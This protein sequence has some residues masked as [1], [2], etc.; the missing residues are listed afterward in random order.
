V[1]RFLFALAA[2]VAASAAATAH[3]VYVVPAPDG[4]E[5]AVT[6]VFSDNLEADEKVDIAKVGGL[7]LTGRYATGMENEI[8]LKADKHALKGKMKGVLP[9]VAFGSVDYG[10]IAKGDAKPALLR[11]HPKAV[12]AGTDEQSATIGK[13]AIELVPVVEGGKV[14][15]RVLAAGKPVPDV[16]VSVMTPDG[17]KDKVKADKDGRTPAFDGKGRFA[18]FAKYAEP[19]AGEAG[20]KKY[21]EIR[22]YATLVFDAGK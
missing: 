11:Y 20:G 19:T 13:A 8:A 22:H 14:L 12:L 17:K 3:M 9:Q 2:A 5:V 4:G 18:A 10:V 1:T 21:E 7:K 16:E 6:V 15:F